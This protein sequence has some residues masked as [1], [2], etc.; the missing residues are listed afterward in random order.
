MRFHIRKTFFTSNDRW[1][2]KN[3]LSQH[4]LL[5]GR[6]PSVD[7]MNMSY[8][9]FPFRLIG[10][11]LLLLVGARMQSVKAVLPDPSVVEAHWRKDPEIFHKTFDALFQK[12]ERLPFW[13][14]DFPPWFKKLCRIIRNSGGLSFYTLND[15][16]K[17]ECDAELKKIIKV[18][19]SR[20]FLEKVLSKEAIES[21]FT[22]ATSG[23]KLFLKIEFE[24]YFKDAF[25][26]PLNKGSLSMTICLMKNFFNTRENMQCFFVFNF[27]KENNVTVLKNFRAEY[28]AGLNEKAMGFYKK[29]NKL[30]DF[31]WNAVREAKKNFPLVYKKLRNDLTDGRRK[32]EG[33]KICS[34]AKSAKRT[35]KLFLPKD[36]DA[37]SW[38]NVELLLNV[39][40][41]EDFLKE[42][43][44]KTF[45]NILEYY[46]LRSLHVFFD[47]SKYDKGY[48]VS[49][50]FRN[51]YRGNLEKDAVA[52]SDKSEWRWL[53]FN[54]IKFVFFYDPK[55][56]EISHVRLQDKL[57]LNYELIQKG[58]AEDVLLIADDDDRDDEFLTQGE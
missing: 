37:D 11:T 22:H 55:K 26:N 42:V 36:I 47:V 18:V 14:E 46:I 29:T 13:G 6:I 20:E 15:L 33:F 58:E 41:T 27:E 53:D 19:G 12:A 16:E 35:V 56:D 45:W 17:L 39:L 54:Y 4:I 23:K 40:I 57:I 48:K 10:C 43:F 50:K 5:V 31:P 8:K 28:S 30:P 52:F 34:A 24:P 38:S 1:K 9:N 7:I 25:F 2:K 44:G 3:F 21:I 49:Y 51:D 32:Y